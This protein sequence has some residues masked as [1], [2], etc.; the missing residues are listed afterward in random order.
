MTTGNPLRTTRR[1]LGRSAKIIAF[2][3]LAVVAL[4]ALAGFLWIRS[5]QE[6]FPELTGSPEIGTWYGIY[7]EGARSALGEPYHGIFRR[8]S[9]N[10]VMVLFNGGGAA[11]DAQ[12]ASGPDRAFNTD[13]GG[14]VL[15]RLGLGSDD[16]ANP[17]ADWTV[18][19]LPYTT[20]DFHIGAGDFTFQNADGETET[21]HH[22]GFLNFDLVMAEIMPH[23][24][25]PE[26]LLISGYSAGGFAAAL[27][28]DHVM[29][30]FPETSDVTVAVDS[31]LL[32]NDDWHG[33][34][35]NIWQPPAE[36]TRQI[37]GDNLT[38]DALTALAADHPQVKVLFL[39]SI[40]DDALVEVQEYFDTGTMRK[41]S[42]G[43]DAYEAALADFVRALRAAVPN[44]A[45]YIFDTE[46][47]EEN[48]TFH[49]ALLLFS[50]TEGLAPITPAQWIANAV[51][52]Q[53][54]DVGLDLLP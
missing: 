16:A 28:A 18:I 35:A 54:E 22:N 32:L 50:F 39:S 5:V 7:P 44:T 46:R 29:G 8:G 31:A 3:T 34:A 4:V 10:N 41:T 26:R 1:L 43:G 48:L 37:T 47:S 27:M 49:T 33:I 51:N 25:A 45:F 53:I 23:L 14:D 24:P 36:I 13:T 30:Y 9:S 40:R 12:T 42:A 2:A 19:N 38:L 6:S 17:F 52:G 20:G 15:A 21:L 11:V